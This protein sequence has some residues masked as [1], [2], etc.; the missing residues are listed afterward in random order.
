MLG[1]AWNSVTM[2][3]WRRN[4]AV[5]MVASL[6]FKRANLDIFKVILGRTPWATGLER[7]GACESQSAFKHHFFQVQDWC[8]PKSKKLSKN[9]KRPSWKSKKLVDKLKGKNAASE[10]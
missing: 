9:S 2:R 6:D 3:W 1:A 8:I 5:S 7:M 4:E 10:M